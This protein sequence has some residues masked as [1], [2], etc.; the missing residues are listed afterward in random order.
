MQIP[1]LTAIKASFIYFYRRIFNQ[2]HEKLFGRITLAVLVIIL[3]WGAGYFFSFL[4][5][6]PGHPDAYWS[7]LL[8]EENECVNTVMLHNAYG[9][10]DV[11]L[12]FIVI[13]LPIPWVS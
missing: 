5:I 4:F 11:V 13:L 1:A 10:S 3:I 7:T 9:I 8:D 12:D 6:C 2:G